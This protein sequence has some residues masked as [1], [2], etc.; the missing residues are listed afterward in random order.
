M[1]LRNKYGVFSRVEL[2]DQ[3]REGNLTTQELGEIYGLN[4]SRIV[5]VLRCLGITYRNPL[6]K[7][8][9][10]EFQITPEI[11]QI[12]LGTL[13]G[14]AF[15]RNPLCYEVMH[16]INQTGY[17][18]HIAEQLCPSVSCISYRRMPLGEALHLWT[19]RHPSFLPYFDL[20]YSRGKTKKHITQS[21][22]YDLDARGL[23]YWYMDDGKYG[24]LRVYLCVGNVTE[25][26]G[27]VLVRFLK[28]RFSLE[29]IFQ[30]HNKPKGHYN[31]YIKAE[32][33]SHFLS[34]IDS[35]IIPSM[36]YK[37]EG[38]PYPVLKRR[39]DIVTHHIGLCEAVGR[40][41]CFTGQSEI[42]SEVKSLIKIVDPKKSYIESIRQKI[43]SGEMVSRTSMRQEPSKEAL[44]QFFLEGLTDAE[45]A[46]KMGFGRNRIARLRREMGI[47][48]KRRRAIHKGIKLE[49][50]HSALD[51]ELEIKRGL[52]FFKSE[53]SIVFQ[54]DLCKG[55]TPLFKGADAVYAEPPWQQ[56]YQAFLQRSG[57]SGSTFG[58]FLERILEI[59]LQLGI[60][61]YLILGKHMVS[62]LKP[63][64]QIPLRLRGRGC[65]LGVWGESSMPLAGT[66]IEVLDY[67]SDRYSNVLDF[68]CG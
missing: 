32:S 64:M 31:I 59:I 48:R 43:S 57:V 65:L 68:C 58:I 56:G 18:Y 33:R 30:S 41:I 2:E 35:Y 15:M 12:L 47:E 3:L 40:E 20:F 21:A 36:R 25:D 8:R 28:S 9:A 51:S 23:A 27:S 39:S 44:I 14:D 24:N 63:P 46:R 29:T 53:G 67:V 26:E 6:S 55:Y 4:Q 7:I 16:S 13:L 1:I 66:N 42:Q 61:S 5:Q 54:Y 19:N 62:R 45:V 10:P 17:L 50:Y 37:I 60:P 38:K 34:L 22:I 49:S 52:D 11:H